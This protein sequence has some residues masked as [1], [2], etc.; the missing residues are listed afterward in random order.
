MERGRP[1]VQPLATRAQT[2]GDSG[3]RRHMQE[4]QQNHLPPA[5]LARADDCAHIHIRIF[6]SAEQVSKAARTHHQAW[7]AAA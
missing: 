1:D 2:T 4:Q 5:A 3:E 7:R 6:A